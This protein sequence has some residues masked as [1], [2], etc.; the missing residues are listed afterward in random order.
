MLNFIFV[1]LCTW[2]T[3]F[4]PYKDV[5]V[6]KVQDDIVE[7]IETKSKNNYYSEDRFD[8]KY[9]FNALSSD[10][11]WTNMMNA[12]L[13]SDLIFLGGY[14]NVGN[15]QVEVSNY[16]IYNGTYTWYASD[17][18]LSSCY[19]YYTNNGELYQV[20]QSTFYYSFITFSCSTIQTSAKLMTLSIGFSGVI[21]SSQTPFD[22][23][24]IFKSMFD[25]RNNFISC[26]LYPASNFYDYFGGYTDLLSFPK[27]N[28]SLSLSA[29]ETLDYNH[30]YYNGYETGY[31]QGYNDKQI[32]YD[33]NIYTD[34]YNEGVIVGYRDGIADATSQGSVAT[35]IFAG[36][37]DVSMIPVNVFLQMFNYE[38]FGI[39]VAGLISGLITIALIL[40][41]V[42]FISGRHV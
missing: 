15:Q 6:P 33:E 2:I 32:F 27:G 25:S 1:A 16:S 40:I 22:T 21:G 31:N 11:Y 20:D 10:T 13:Q 18:S 29:E 30:G 36:I 34:G 19:I 24:I 42:R 37:L 8:V 17:T 7:V 12:L 28:F 14:A 35:E 5:C 41:L 39:N 23:S 4:L 3:T 26:N 38:V 9:S